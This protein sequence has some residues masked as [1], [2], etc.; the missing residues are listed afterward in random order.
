MTSERRRHNLYEE[1]KQV[2]SPDSADEFMS[3][4]PPVGWADVATRA[5]LAIMRN[6]TDALRAELRGEMAQLR[7]EMDALGSELRG[8]MAQLRGEMDALR[9]ELRGEMAALRSE[10][11][12]EMRALGAGLR[13]DMD[14][15]RS[16]LSRSQVVQLRWTMATLVGTMTL[17]V[18]AV[19]ILLG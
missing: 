7:G 9:S 1:A 16:D 19:S 12:G 10:L 11:R 15:L 13:G 3:Y 17:G 18:G 6:E 14:A 8:E 2:F 4:F 5:D